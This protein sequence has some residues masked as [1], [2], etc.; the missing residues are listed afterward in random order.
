MKSI[1]QDEKECYL[2]GS[3]RFLEEHHI[4]GGANRKWSEKYGLKVYLCHYCH[5]EPPL[6]VHFN[7]ERN[8]YLKKAGQLKFTRYYNKNDEEFRQVFGKNYLD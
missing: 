2:C 3:T 7:Q 6:G 1:M 4:F 5:N 8:L